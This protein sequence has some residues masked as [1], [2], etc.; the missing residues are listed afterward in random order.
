[1]K[2]KILGI[3]F[4]IILALVTI[5]MYPQ[6]QKPGQAGSVKGGTVSTGAMRQAGGQ[7]A[8]ESSGSVGKSLAA[9][10]QNQSVWETFLSQATRFFSSSKTSSGTTTLGSLRYKKT[11]TTSGTTSSTTSAYSG[12]TSGSPTST[13]TSTTTSSTPTSTSGTTTGTSGSTSGTSSGTSSVP[14]TSG[15]TSTSTTP[16]TSDP[17]T[18]TSTGTGT[19]ATTDTTSTSTSPTSGTTSG[20]TSSGTSSTTTSTSNRWEFAGW[21]GGGSFPKLIADAKNVG[22]LYL[23]SDVSGLWRSDDR[24]DNW[25][26]ITAG[27]SFLNGAA[28]AVAPSDSNV[29][30]NL[31]GNGLFYTSNAGASW[32]KVNTG[33]YAIVFGK[34]SRPIAISAASSDKICV[35]TSLGK[36]FCSTNH[37][38]AWQEIATDTAYFP[39]G[40]PIAAMDYVN[41]DNALLVATVTGLYQYSFT[42]SKWTPV[43][44]GFAVP[45]FAVSRFSS[46]IIYVAG[47]P[48]LQITKNGGAT[49]S[50]S[51]AVPSGNTFRVSLYENTTQG[52]VVYAGNET[53]SMIVSRDGG[54]TW[55]SLS[56]KLNSDVVSDPTRS[57]AVPS[58]SGIR[59]LQ[60]DPFDQNIVYRTDSWGAWRSSDGGLTWLEKIKGAPNICGTD[61]AFGPS[62]VL[63]ASAMDNGLLKSTDMGQTY[64]AIFPKTSADAYGDAGGHVWRVK[65][66]S[67]QRV[68]ATSSP[69]GTAVN[70]VAVSNDGG[71]TFTITRSGLPTA[72]PRVNVISGEGYPKALAVDP[73]LPNNVYI[74]IDGDDGGGLYI[75]NNGGDTWTRSAGQPG[76]LRIFRGLAV[77]G[78]NSN[79]IYWGAWGSNGGI[80]ISLDRGK[81]WQL[82]LNRTQEIL[83]IHAASDGAVYAAGNHLGAALFVSKNQGA[84][85]EKIA[86][87][88][89][90][91]Y[92][93][94]V[95]TS[96]VSSNVIAASTF[97][98]SLNAPQ[99]VFLSIDSGLT[100]KDVTGDLPLGTGAAAMTFSNDGQYL[101]FSRYT[102]GVYRMKVD[103][104]AISG[105]A[106]AG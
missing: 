77:D 83:D 48:T 41:N 25:R 15:T 56:I 50:Q 93:N 95:V 28:I 39:A 43:L 32:S 99:K 24:G 34:A 36:I 96:P 86:Q 26:F 89:N 69:W 92:A 85:W 3:L 70:Q 1:M 46:A 20:S 61:V 8:A 98:L 63:F 13:G 90:T 80:Y 29:V 65:A 7:T 73:Q 6:A 72:R 22:R 71:A 42:L 57:W 68:I 47:G 88:A 60:V 21:Y 2:A 97:S 94:A 101:Y 5:K 54:V 40:K 82:S 81:T 58:W 11:V 23:I 100:W 76:S 18:S 9:S 53:G 37:G 14:V 75:S 38:G 51:A 74:G 102:G 45:D 106:I 55:S 17:A 49:W 62:G 84:S 87:F 64:T 30:Y 66:L 104:Q 105:G 35:G 44:T 91:D 16:T 79:I 31:V 10:G 19:A 78:K 67:A 59:S 103:S 4:I 12:V 52:G 27:V 33:N